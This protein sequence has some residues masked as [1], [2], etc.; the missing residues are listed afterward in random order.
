MDRAVIGR[1]VDVPVGIAMPAQLRHGALLGED[2]VHE[3]D[4]SVAVGD[5][6]RAQSGADRADRLEVGRGGRGAGVGEAHVELLQRLDRRE[7]VGSERGVREVHRRL[8]R[9]DRVR[10]ERHVDTLPT[11]IVVS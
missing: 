5:E 3:G 11:A 4:R 8:Q 10:S 9:F 6:Q 2:R 7:R 1:G